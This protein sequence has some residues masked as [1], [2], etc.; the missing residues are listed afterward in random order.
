V[1]L[2]PKRLQEVIWNLFSNALKF[3][4]AGGSV[5]ATLEYRHAGFQLAIADN[6]KGISPENIPHLFEPLW[7]AEGGGKQ[8]GLGL[9][10]AIAKNLVE[11]HG[12]SI[13]AE[14]SGAGQ[15]AAFVVEIPWS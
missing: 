6:G 14:S 13:R 8:G 3:T 1:A 4:P 11:L 15:G 2:D 5:R 7:Q 10:L 12:G 9:G